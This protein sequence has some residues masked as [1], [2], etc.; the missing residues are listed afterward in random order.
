MNRRERAYYTVGILYTLY[1]FGLDVTSAPLHFFSFSRHLFVLS[2]T[3]IPFLIVYYIG[4][5]QSRLLVC[6]RPGFLKG[7]QL[8][9]KLSKST[10]QLEMV[11]PLVLEGDGRSRVS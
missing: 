9:I 1:H 4:Y 5:Y 3:M 6:F 7:L 11:V 8:Y 10:L 2:C